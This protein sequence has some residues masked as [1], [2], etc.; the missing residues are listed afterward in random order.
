[1]SLSRSVLGLLAGS[2]LAATPA[3]AAVTLDLASLTAVEDDSGW[4]LHF[5][6]SGSGDVASATLT[7]PGGSALAIPCEVLEEGGSAC[8]FESQHFPS[9]VALLESFSSGSYLLSLNG[10]ART[11]SLPFAPVAPDGLATAT[12]PAAGAVFVSSTP[13]VSWTHDCTNCVALGVDIADVDGPFDV[14]LERFVIGDP[15]PSPGSVS[16]AELE[17]YEGPKPAFLPEGRYALTLTTAVGSIS[18]GH[19]TPGG[20]AFEYSTGGLRDAQSEFTVPE[21]GAAA[22]V[23]AVLVALAGISR[24]RAAS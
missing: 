23:I 2:V 7:P 12:S 20:D 6:L 18:T 15:V 5:E 24:R 21:P 22:A 10:G 3:R 9:L 11:A 14:G 19:L 17:S 13:A 8:E 4:E 16:Y 1:M